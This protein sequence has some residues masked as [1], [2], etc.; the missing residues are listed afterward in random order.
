MDI[1]RLNLQPVSE[2]EVISIFLRGELKSKR[3]SQNI[4]NAI[5]KLNTN[6]NLI[7]NPD[8]TKSEDNMLRKEILE[9]TR[10]YISRE[11]LFE[12]FPNDIKWYRVEFPST[13]LVNEV[14]YID[15]DYWIKL[16]NGSR[17]PKDA[18]EKIK[19]NEMV[20]NVPYDN[21][22]EASEQF[23]KNKSF[24]EIILV[25]DGKEFVVLEGHLRLTAYVLKKDIL[26]ENLSLIIGF[27][28][29]MKAWSNF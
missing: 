23:Q 11:G 3:F 13:S 8:L 22:V 24:D 2:D 28:E 9:E 17:L 6:K 5:R 15:Y 14:K 27:S 19:R 4:A 18:V 29:K 10:K 7:L 26:P 25:S 12:G 16:T 1:S 20:F 21:F